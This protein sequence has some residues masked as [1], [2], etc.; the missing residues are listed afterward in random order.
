MPRF[1]SLSRRW[2]GF[3]LIELLVV[4][5]IIAVLVGMLLPAVQKVREAANRASS[6]NNLKQIGLAIFSCHD[7]F[8]KLPTTLG[9]FPAT[10]NGTDWGANPVPSHFGT[11]QYF[12]LPFLEQ[13]NAFKDRIMGFG[14]GNN[15]PH[16]ANSWW[17]DQLV[18][19][20]QAPGDPSMPANGRA[21][22]TG[23]HNLARGLTSYAANWHALGGGW[24]EDWQIGGKARIPNSFPDGQSS[25]ILFFERYARC[26][27]PALEGDWGS[28]PD[29]CNR[30]R[31]RANVWNEDGQNSGPIAQ[32]Y[33]AFA[34]EIPAWWVSYKG[35]C[36][37]GPNWGGNPGKV[38]SI[39]PLP[40]QRYPLWYPMSFVPLPQSAPNWKTQCD[41]SR[42]QSLTS[43]GLGV[44]F[45]DGSVK[46]VN[47]NITQLTW[48]MLIVPDDGLVVSDY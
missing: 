23:G 42:L 38:P 7:T 14:N 39:G 20:Y 37:G 24:D 43:G 32:N 22:A 6:Q 26:G 31:Y 46:N 5:A 21:W 36:N 1:L 27:D 11:L 10:G 47:T 9:C 4:I 48:A 40:A 2:R 12:I 33:T 45:A 15:N 18:K 44:L 13:D 34:W 3:T 25:T 8:G 30:Q 16:Q 17:S 35:S 19:T 41:P 28:I 29:S